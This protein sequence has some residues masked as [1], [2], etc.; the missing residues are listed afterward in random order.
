MA[1]SANVPDEGGIQRQE[2]PE[3]T[4]YSRGIE[5]RRVSAVIRETEEGIHLNQS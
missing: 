2:A 4:R 5:L 3:D 1:R